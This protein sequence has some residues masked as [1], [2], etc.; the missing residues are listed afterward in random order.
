M[1]S[2]KYRSVDE[3]IYQIPWRPTPQHPHI[4]NIQSLNENKVNHV[5]RQYYPPSSYFIYLFRWFAMMHWQ[6]K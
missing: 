5:N 3:N 1:I 4:S 2:Q 6:E